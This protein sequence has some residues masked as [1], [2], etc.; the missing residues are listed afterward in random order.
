MIYSLQH[1]KKGK[2]HLIDEEGSSLCG[3][4]GKHLLWT[5]AHELEVNSGLTEI[6][7]GSRGKIADVS[8]YCTKC[9]KKAKKQ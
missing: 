4:I 3:V 7:N 9:I 2:Y 6:Y 5:A 8:L 1:N